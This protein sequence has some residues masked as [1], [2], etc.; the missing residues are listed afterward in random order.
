MPFALVII[1]IVLLVAAIRNTLSGPGGLL[2]LLKGDF[3]GPNNFIYWMVAILIIGAIGYIPDLKKLSVAFITLVIVVLFL[4]RG[5]AQGIGG[6]FFTQ[7]A[8]ALSS[9]QTASP[10]TTAST[11]TS[12]G[13]GTFGLP[14]LSTIIPHL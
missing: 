11:S 13:T 14:N 9:T 12:T 6:G 8:T 5:N 1:G 10:S 2:T 4:K 3:T 7:F